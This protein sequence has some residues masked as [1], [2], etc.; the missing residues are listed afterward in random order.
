MKQINCLSY[1]KPKS[2]LQA[3]QAYYD[4]DNGRRHL[5]GNFATINEA[6]QARDC[7]EIS[8]LSSGNLSGAL[9][10]ISKHYDKTLWQLSY[11][12]TSFG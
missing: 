4:L 2:S 10:S 6:V 1:L 9:K 5:I 8:L 3:Y 11:A 12:Q 7:Y